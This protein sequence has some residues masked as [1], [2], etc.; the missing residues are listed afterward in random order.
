MRQFLSL[1][2]LA[3]APLM[4]QDPVDARGWI[5]RGV[6]A[7]KQ[8]RYPEALEA[9]QKAVQLD[10]ANM[11]ARLYLGTAYLQQFIPG[12]ELPQNKQ[13]AQLATDEFV[14]VVDLDPR[15]IVAMSSLASLYMNQKRWDDALEWYGKL[16]AV[17]P[18]NAGAYYSVGFIA[19]SRWYPAYT[20]ARARLGM[21]L[22]DPGPI[23]D[24]L[25]KQ[26]LKATYGGVIDAGMHAMEKA[27]QINPQ[28][29]DAMAYM[30]L[31]VQERADLRDTL[32]EYRQDIATADQWIQMALATKKQKVEQRPRSSAPPPPPPPPPPP[33]SPS[34]PAR[35]S[36]DAQVQ[37]R[38]LINKVDPV[39]PPMARQARV[40]GTVFLTVIVD[41]EGCVSDIRVI[42]GQPL[43]IPAAMEAVKQWVYQPTLLNGNPVEVLTQVG[44]VF[45][46]VN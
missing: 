30:N 29:D 14:K 34:S 25:V 1:L 22:E 38:K 37:E 41:R 11:T 39:Y 4:A 27:L 42:S 5:N 19:W 46:P 20:A 13:M 6:Q 33:S 9:F 7:Y 8:A 26:D 17:D 2:L 24:Q 28:Y 44:V 35:I 10:P 36:V 18:N 40:S 45:S 3:L 23:Q 21:K 32:E 12:V 43:L 31:F 15:N 16:T